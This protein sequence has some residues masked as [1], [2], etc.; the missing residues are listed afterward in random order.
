M[1]TGFGFIAKIGDMVSRVKAGKA[2]M[3]LDAQAV[4]LLSVPL[5]PH[6]SLDELKTLAGGGRGLT[7]IGLEDG[8]TL[9]QTAAFGA[10]GLVLTGVGRGGKPAEATLSLAALAP[11]LGKRARR[12]RAPA[13]KFKATGLRPA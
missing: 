7:L 8:E 12:G 10:A 11:V 9:V 3:T 13:I 1:S 6:A 4:P 2:F 5:L